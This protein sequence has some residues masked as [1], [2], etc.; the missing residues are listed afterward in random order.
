MAQTPRTP[1]AGDNASPDPDQDARDAGEAREDPYGDENIDPARQPAPPT[2]GKRG[3]SPNWLPCELVGA[4]LARQHAAREGGSTSKAVQRQG[5]AA[6]VYSQIILALDDAGLCAW[7]DGK[8]GRKLPGSARDSATHRT[9]EHVYTKIY[10]KGDTVRA[11]LKLY[12]QT[13][14]RLYVLISKNGFEPSTGDNDGTITWRATEEAC[15]AELTSLPV[16][17]DTLKLAYR[18]SCSSSPYL[19]T[20]KS[21]LTYVDATCALDPAKRLDQDDVPSERELK[22][23]QKRRMKEAG[24]DKAFGQIQDH[25]V[26]DRDDALQEELRGFMAECKAAMKTMMRDDEAGC[27]A[28]QVARKTTELEERERKI[29]KTEEDLI[30]RLSQVESM[31]MQLTA[32]FDA[33]KGNKDIQS[34]EVENDVTSALP[35]RPSPKEMSAVAAIPEEETTRRSTRPRKPKIVQD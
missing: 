19:P 14:S 7:S 2:T 11:A 17:L 26:I 25:A 23:H 9:D 16:G 6:R 18:I 34:P 4:F 13:F 27:D 22:A 31:Q 32:M 29:Q 20:D 1:R 3:R 33:A 30:A 35:T 24:N 5:L 21:L 28:E 15:A 8:D 12:T 10:P